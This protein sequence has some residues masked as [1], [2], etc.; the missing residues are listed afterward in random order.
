[1]RIPDNLD[2]FEMH[3][4]EQDRLERHREAI[5]RLEEKEEDEEHEE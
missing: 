2:I 5:K 1:M 3:E 4:R